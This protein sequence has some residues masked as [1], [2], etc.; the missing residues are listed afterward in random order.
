M[1][2]F[3]EIAKNAK[4]F[5]LALCY[6]GRPRITSDRP[7]LDNVAKALDNGLSLAMCVPYPL[8]LAMKVKILAIFYWLDITLA[9]GEA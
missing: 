4:N 6:S 7:V 2:L 1:D 5:L 8:S 9:Y 3:A